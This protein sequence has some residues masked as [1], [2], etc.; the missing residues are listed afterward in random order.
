MKFSSSPSL[1]LRAVIITLLS[2]VFGCG[3]PGPRAQPGDILFDLEPEYRDVFDVFGD[4]WAPVD[5]AEFGSIREIH[6][7]PLDQT[8]LGSILLTSAR[9]SFP[10]LQPVI[11]RSFLVGETDDPELYQLMR[12]N[13]VRLLRRNVDGKPSTNGPVYSAELFSI[14]IAFCLNG[15]EKG[16]NSCL[17]DFRTML[18]QGAQ[19]RFGQSTKF[20]IADNNYDE[21]MGI[22]DQVSSWIR[23]I[24][25]PAKDSVIAVRVSRAS[26]AF[27]NLETMTGEVTFDHPVTVYMHFPK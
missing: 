26:C 12:R 20:I 6:W 9:A 15:Y 25:K 4:I 14:S 8:V 17:T 18:K 16:S 21:S 13:F 19:F 24:I 2:H 5:N 1:F 11:I 10:S 27:Y 3:S 22:P 23:T 7:H